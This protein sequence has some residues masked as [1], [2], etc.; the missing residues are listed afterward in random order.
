M[1]RSTRPKKPSRTS[2]VR[3]HKPVET[4]IEQ[5]PQYVVASAPQQTPTWMIVALMAVSAIAGYFF[6]KA[7]S[8]TQGTAGVNTQQAAQQQQQQQRP[9]TMDIKKPDSKDRIRGNAN[10]RY[11]IVEYSDLECP[12]CKR[13]HPDIAKLYEQN[14]NELAWVYRHFPLSFHPKAQK[15]AEAVEC[16]YE[17]GGNEGFWQMTDAIY[18]AMPDM[19]LAQLPDVASKAGLDSTAMKTCIDSGK[20]EKF[21]TGQRDE[22]TKAGVAATPTNVFYD[23]KTGKTL[24]V[25]GAVPFDQLESSFNTFKK[26]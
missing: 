18:E 5:Q 19:E 22:G 11:M 26:S 6:F 23:T 1:A 10:A 8:L 2:S 13:A 7:Q 14:K 4:V 20:H 16:A 15:S 12:F 24:V 21:V 9:T 17:L 3:A 25:E